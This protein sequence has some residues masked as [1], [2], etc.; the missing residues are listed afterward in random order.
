MWYKD[1]N[2]CFFCSF[3]IVNDTLLLA[4]NEDSTSVQLQGKKKRKKKKE[5]ESPR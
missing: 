3:C 4:K 5:D 2:F 1:F